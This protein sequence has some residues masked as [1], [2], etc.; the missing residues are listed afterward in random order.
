M[1]DGFAYQIFISKQKTA[2]EKNCPF[3]GT[4]C[5]EIL[6]MKIFYHK[7]L[8]HFLQKV[9]PLKYIT[10]VFTI[11]VFTH[12]F[13]QST[14][15]CIVTPVQPYPHSSQSFVRL[16]NLLLC[17]TTCTQNT[18]EQ[19]FLLRRFV[20]NIVWTKKNF[21]IFTSWHPVIKIC[22]WSGFSIFDL[23]LGSNV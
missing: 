12:Q 3:D 7:Y 9:I 15:S 11:G 5:I 23:V 6:F 13:Y 10:D 20:G 16:D 8:Y 18:N 22:L 1:I 14:F 4:K 21:F 2:W 19:D 17:L